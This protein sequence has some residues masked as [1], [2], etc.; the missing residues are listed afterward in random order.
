M[1]APTQA[2]L[3][4]TSRMAKGCT[5]TVAEVV[6]VIGFANEVRVLNKTYTEF[7]VPVT[8]P[9]DVFECPHNIGLFIYSTEQA[10]TQELAKIKIIVTGF[11]WLWIERD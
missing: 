3:L 7:C 4:V 2:F 1:P 8:F 9:P 6:E 11:K 10:F 5:A